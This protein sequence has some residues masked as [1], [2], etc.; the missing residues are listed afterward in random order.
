MFGT[1]TSA[2]VATLKS[3]HLVPFC[4]AIEGTAA[5]DNVTWVHF[6]PSAMGPPPP[7]VLNFLS[8]TQQSVSSVSHSLSQKKCPPPFEP[9]KANDH[10]SKRGK[11]ADDDHNL[12]VDTPS[13]YDADEDY[14]NITSA[15][16]TSGVANQNIHE[17]DAEREM[18]ERHSKNFME[19]VFAPLDG[20]D[21]CE[22]EVFHLCK[23]QEELDPIAYVVSNW[24][25]GM[26]VCVCV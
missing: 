25:P 15:L 18:I 3:P 2:A 17:W 1:Y 23:P 4:G 5:T 8:K 10:N 21:G 13:K 24:Q 7:R 22:M 6:T 12:H 19:R 16:E 26:C 14:I 11:L 20:D 9:P